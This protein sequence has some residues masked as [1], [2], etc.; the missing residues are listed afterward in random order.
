MPTN[1]L[2]AAE[3]R[4]AIGAQQAPDASRPIAVDSLAVGIHTYDGRCRL[5]P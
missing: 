2:R 3:V 4:P 5:L 1:A